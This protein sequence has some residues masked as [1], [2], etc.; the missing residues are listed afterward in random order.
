MFRNNQAELQ[1]VITGQDESAV[2]TAEITWQSDGHNVSGT[3][4]P[5]KSE[6][7]QYSKTSTMTRSRAEWERGNKVGCSAVTREGTTIVRELSVHT[8]GLLLTNTSYRTDGTMKN[9]P[10]KPHVSSRWD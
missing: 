6:G 7:G 8:G 2:Q 9:L 1:C 4:G 5:T 3:T 10:A